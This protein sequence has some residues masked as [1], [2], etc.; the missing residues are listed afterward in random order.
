MAR[1]ETRSSGGALP[2]GTIVLLAIAGCF[3]VVMLLNIRSS[4]SGDA[5]VGDAIAWLFFTASLWIML[6][7]ALVAGGVAGTMLR[8]AVWVLLQPLAGA[9]LVVSGDFYSRHRTLPPLEP[10]ILPLLIAFYALWARLPALQARLPARPT[11]LVVWCAVAT[12]SVT[13]MIVAANYGADGAAPLRRH[14]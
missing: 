12:I 11:S 7:I 5:V 6:T 1:E 9:A 2:I 14:R 10:T 13:S 4:S 8:P 3:Y